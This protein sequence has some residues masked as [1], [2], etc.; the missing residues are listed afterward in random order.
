MP[1]AVVLH[2]DDDPNDTE[3][4]R[5]ATR[6]AE[7]PFLLHNVEDGDQAMAY[8][9]SQG[10][11]ANRERYRVPSLVLLDLKMPRATGFEILKWIRSHPQFGQIP[12]VVL[13]GSELQDDINHAYAVGANS[14]LIKP[15]G[16]DA[17]V[18][19]VKDLNAVWLSG[20]PAVAQL[21]SVPA[22]SHSSE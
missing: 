11:Y 10:T 20:Q 7:V 13:S 18:N 19:L 8:L 1:P 14:Y 15:L 9:N 5:A 12:V 21:P 17:L 3:L 2:V 4:L 16:F 6:K 22:V